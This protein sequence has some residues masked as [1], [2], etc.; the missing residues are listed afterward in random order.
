MSKTNP[1]AKKPAKAK[2]SSDRIFGSK[3]MSHGFT[4]IPNILMRGQKRLGLSTTQFNILVQLLSYYYDPDNPPFPSKRQLADRISI[5]TQTLRINIKALEEAGFLVRKQR[6]TA[7]GDF[8]SNTYHLDG[9]IKKLEK[10][11]PDFDQERKERQAARRKT[12]RPNARFADADAVD[13]EN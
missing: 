11:V 2:S 3:I 8:G 12:E 5:T 7:A 10:L 4:G 1:E 6:K 9:L 13:G